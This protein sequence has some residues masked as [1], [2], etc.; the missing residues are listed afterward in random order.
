MPCPRGNC[1]DT[2]REVAQ[3]I[4]V[5]LEGFEGKGGSTVLKYN[6][7]RPDSEKK[8]VVQQMGQIMHHKTNSSLTSSD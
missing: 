8:R 7:A 1:R 5:D 3:K 2:R 4:G 6:K